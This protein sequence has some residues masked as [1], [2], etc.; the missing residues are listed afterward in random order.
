MHSL[1]KFFLLIV[2]FS[3][4]NG[5][6]VLGV[7]LRPFACWD[8]GFESRR[9]HGCLSLY[10]CCVSSGSGLCDGLD[11]RPERSTECDVSECDRGA[12]QRKPRLI[13]AVER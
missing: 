3:G 12:S 4:P 13:G 1:S 7:C 11:T 2:V 9:G 8:C 10:Q 6:A 5:R